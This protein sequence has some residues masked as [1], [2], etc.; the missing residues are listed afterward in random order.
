MKRIEINGEFADLSEESIGLNW[1]YFD[2]SNPGVRINPFTSTI[3]LPF[4]A[5]NKRLLGYGDAIGGNM[6]GIRA[7][8]NVNYWLGAYK[9]ISNGYL[10]VTEIDKAYI[11]SITAKNSTVDLLENLTFKE[12]LDDAAVV[13]GT[14]I[15]ATL[16]SLRDGTSGWLLPRV[17]YDNI[18]S[19]IWNIGG[20]FGVAVRHELW[21]KISTLFD[22]IE[23]LTGVSFKIIEDGDVLDLADSVIYTDY[24]SKM[25]TP[26]WKYHLLKSQ[27][28]FLTT[29]LQETS[30][31]LFTEDKRIETPLLKIFGGLSPWSFIKSVAQ[32][33]GSII[34]VSNNVITII[35]LN[36]LKKFT[37]VNLSGKVEK[38]KKSIN[39]PG[40]EARNIVGYK[41]TDNLPNSFGRILITADV[42]PDVEKE[43]FVFDL[44]LP[45]MYVPS[46]YMSTS[47]TFFNTNYGSNQDLAT[48]PLIL[49]DGGDSVSTTVGYGSTT[50][51]G[52]GPIT[53]PAYYGTVN[54][55]VLTYLPLTGFYTEYQ[56]WLTAGIYFEA[57]VALN[58]FDFMRLRPYKLVWIP[59]LGGSFFVNKITN[60]DPY[61]GKPAKMQLVKADVTVPAIINT[62]T[63]LAA[64]AISGTEITL[65]WDDNSSIEDGWSLERK[66]PPGSWS[67]VATSDT[68]NQTTYTDDTCDPETLYY[69]RIRSTYGAEYSDYSNEA[70]AETEASPVVDPVVT[71]EPATGT[72]TITDNGGSIAIG[73]DQLTFSFSWLDGWNET[74]GVMDYII[75]DGANNTV[76]GYFLIGVSDGEGP[77]GDTVTI[78]R[79]AVSGDVFTVILYEYGI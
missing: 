15:S 37:P 35:S 56:K 18:T 55:K 59:E 79:D 60:F 47:Q 44:C 13:F 28:N 61:S 29:S 27:A 23:N 75:K 68:A 67:V 7:V 22:H 10:K 57:D 5:R 24:L 14:T 73:D 2:V 34:E 71:C 45:G 76:Y 72:F 41:I 51:T 26:T 17:L 42:K 64:V 62:P 11:C 21:I 4:T 38:Y 65:T 49:F 66:L 16:A 48:R 52:W 25:Y 6:D 58:L 9:V 30:G 46:L 78:S 19:S 20:G 31:R 3:K 63:N 36:E 32:I 50:A 1:Q 12:I 43:L 33:F 40:V 54:L 70:S 53:T 39:I 74:P 8:A 69:Y 77:F